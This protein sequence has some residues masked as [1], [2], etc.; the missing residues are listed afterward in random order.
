VNTK[1]T[2][3]I[4]QEAIEYLK[5]EFPIIPLC[6]PTHEG[7]DYSHRE[8]CHSPGKAPLIK[9]WTAHSKTSLK[10]INS[11][12]S[13]NRAL[14]IGIPL[15]QISHMV[16]LDIDGEEGEKLLEAV[17]GG[18]IPKTWEFTT[19]KGRRLLYKIPE[20]IQTKKLKLTGEKKK[21]EFAIICDGQQTVLPPSLHSSG[22]RY[23][24]KEDCSPKDIEIT[25]AP[26]WVLDQIVLTDTGERLAEAKTITTIGNH[27]TEDDFKKTVT[28]G[29]RNDHLTRLTGSQLGR[30]V[31]KEQVLFFIKNWNKMQCDP[32]LPESEIVAMVE[33]IALAEEM[34]RS[35][36]TRSDAKGRPVFKP[37][38]FARIF[39]NLQKGMGY[40]WKYSTEMGTFFRCDDMVGPW[41]RMDIVFVQ[42]EVRRLIQDR[43]KGGN[44]FWDT[45]H[46]INEGIEAIKSQLVLPGEEGLFDLGYNVKHKVS[47]YD[48][49]D[50]ICLDNGV[51]DWKTL[52]FQPWSS[53]IYTTIKL[54]VEWK[55][56]AECPYWLKALSEWIPSQ[57]T[58]DFLQEYVG[59]CLIPDTSF[60]IAVFLYGTGANG[61]SMFIDAIRELFGKSLVSIPLHRLTSRFET[62]NL[63]NKLINVC[64]DIDSKYISDTGVLKSIIGG[65]VLRGEFKHGRSFDFYPVCRLMFSANALPKVSDKSSAWYARWQFVEFPNTFLVNS[66]YKIRHARLFEQEKAGILSWA[67][68]GLQRLKKIDNWTSSKPM[69]ESI[70]RYMQENDTVI[71]FIN[72]ATEK[73]QHVG[74][75]TM[76]ST[77]ALHHFYR[78]WLEQN[79]PGSIPVGNYEFSRRITSLGYEKTHRTIAGKDANVFLGIKVIDAYANDYK[80]YEDMRSN[81]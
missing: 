31:P 39:L 17:S 25:D 44:K 5:L 16:G 42:S 43:E 21:Q 15:G 37:T 70:K 69:Q 11:W 40:S 35:K 79:L 75:L 20:G 33:S 50:N 3:D 55:P 32:P 7:M 76:V 14:N 48:P 47:H 67:I 13:K 12:F 38:P 74:T 80:I 57:E 71:A 1:Y 64:G 4:Q 6:S 53:E 23:L 66:T 77:Q 27:F 61:K 8:K 19:G 51:L 78:D 26:R 18:D 24:W 72:E 28:E 73:V 54:P 41:K 68:K 22:R 63:Q 10:D 62:A 36:Q 60:R 52:D 34:K 9:A 45:I 81:L 29:S 59:L 46:C 49:I 58:I 56:E 30:G 2:N 65:D